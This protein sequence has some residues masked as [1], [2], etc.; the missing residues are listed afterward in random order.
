LYLFLI[1]GGAPIATHQLSNGSMT[2]CPKWKKLLKLKQWLTVADAARYLSILF[3]EAE[4]HRP[5][6]LQT[7]ALR[8]LPDTQPK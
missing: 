7:E 3:G 2:R 8:G 4:V 6:R 5:S 1:S